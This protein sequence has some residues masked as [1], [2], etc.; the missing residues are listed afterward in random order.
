MDKFIKQLLGDF[1]FT[2]AALQNQNEQLQEE[3]KKLK[4][5]LDDKI[6]NDDRK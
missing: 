1:A 5:L 3:I 4:L 2:I 6:Q